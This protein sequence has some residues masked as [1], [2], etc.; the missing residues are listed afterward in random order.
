MHSAYSCEGEDVH[1]SKPQMTKQFVQNIVEKDIEIVNDDSVTTPRKSLQTW[2]QD[3]DEKVVGLKQYGLDPSTYGKRQKFMKA[4]HHSRRTGQHE[5]S[6][7][8]SV[9]QKEEKV[10]ELAMHNSIQLLL[11]GIIAALKVMVYYMSK[12]L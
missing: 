9:E 12:F 1:P 3:K 6:G 8:L 2:R 10:R 11:L 4:T 5:P 7:T